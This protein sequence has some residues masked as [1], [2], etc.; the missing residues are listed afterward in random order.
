DPRHDRIVAVARRRGTRFLLPMAGE[1]IALGEL[2]LRVLSPKDLN[3]APA[4]NVNDSA[5]VLVASY[6]HFD[7]LL[8]A[9]AESDVTLGLPLPP[10]DVLKV[11]HHGSEDEGL[12]QLLTRLKPRIAVIEVGDN[13]Y[14]H[15]RAQALA[16]LRAVPSVFRTDRDGEVR[17]SLERGAAVVTT[18]N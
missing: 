4:G 9:D 3:E 2:E 17:I 11:A 5:I 18:R 7:V 14:G 13:P 16:A 1:R 10:V 15:P 8:P 12:P 6:R